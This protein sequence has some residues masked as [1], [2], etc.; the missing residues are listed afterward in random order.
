VSPTESKGSAMIAV[1][2]SPD[3]PPRPWHGPVAGAVTVR[4]RVERSEIAVRT[5][6]ERTRSEGEPWRVR[7]TLFRDP[8]AV[9]GTD[10]RR[11]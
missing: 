5:M 3:R 11:V 1:A 9:K 10:S 7:G 8:R 6:R 2:H 4:S